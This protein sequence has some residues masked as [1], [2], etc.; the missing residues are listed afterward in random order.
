ML[1]IKILFLFLIGLSI[2]L[3]F[4]FDFN[5]YLNPE[6]VIAKK[7]ELDLLYKN[8]PVLFVLAYFVFYVF[9]TA[10]SLP[11]AALLTLIAGFLFNFFIGSLVASVGSTLGATFAFLI[12]RFLLKDFVQKKF[13]SRLQ[14][15]NKGFQ[16]DGAFYL[17]SLRLLPFPFFILNILMGVTPISV[18]SF[19]FASFLGML[20]PTLVYVNA[21]SQLSHIKSPIDIISLPII[22]SF[23]LLA[24]LPWIMKFCLKNFSFKIKS[25][26]ASLLEVSDKS[27]S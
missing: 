14:I 19:F 16:K 25:K 9:C 7:Q 24:C 22:L 10:I 6:T 18:K 20:L 23:L 8:S 4:Y 21:G 3:F 1:K 5:Q 17:F 2:A 27:N 13:S 12:A 26:E 15:I 11:A